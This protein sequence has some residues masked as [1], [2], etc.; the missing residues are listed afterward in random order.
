[1]SGMASCCRVIW[2]QLGYVL[3]V[4]ISCDKCAYTRQSCISFGGTRILWNQRRHMYTQITRIL[5]PLPP[6]HISWS[7]Q[8][9]VIWCQLG[10][11]LGVAISCQGNL[12]L[13]SEVLIY[14]E[15][16]GDLCT[17]RL[18]AY[19]PPPPN[20]KNR[21]SWSGMVVTIF[22]GIPILPNLPEL[23]SVFPS[24]I[25]RFSKSITPSGFLFLSM[26]RTSLA[27]EH[28]VHLL[29]MHT[30]TWTHARKYS[31]VLYSNL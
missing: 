12:V 19:Y 21:S 11:V 8:S 29:S 9:R 25:K 18:L 24:I 10:Y 26:H 22:D 14:L 15:I 30:Y 7:S 3:G 23:I 4:A 1:M 6:N 5:P 27:N 20:H 28:V 2:C 31:L 13:V 16:K 17:H